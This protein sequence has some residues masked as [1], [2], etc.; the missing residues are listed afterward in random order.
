MLNSY[1]R[2]MDVWKVSHPFLENDDFFI[3]F[4]P[5]FVENFMQTE[6]M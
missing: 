3:S 5:S 6:H 2:H 4:R 1:D